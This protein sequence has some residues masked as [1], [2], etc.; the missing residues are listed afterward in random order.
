MSSFVSC[1][2][3]H[4]AKGVG[5]KGNLE[6]NWSQ[7]LEE[8]FVQLYFQLVRNDCDTIEECLD[9][10]I[11]GCCKP[12]HIYPDQISNKSLFIKLFKLIGHTRDIIS[13]KGEYQLTYRQILV[14]YKRFPELAK[15]ATACLVCNS[16]LDGK[17]MHPYGSFK[18][19]KY[20]SK[21]VLKETGDPDH[22]LI[23][24]CCSIF[25]SQVSFDINILNKSHEVGDI[26]LAGR[27]VPGEKSAFA[28]MYEK[29][30][31]YL[32]PDIIAS[33]INKNRDDQGPPMTDK[34]KKDRMNRAR[35]CTKQILRNCKTRLNKHLKTTQIY[36]T[37]NRFSDIDY[38]NVTSITMKNNKLAFQN[39]K[40]DGSQRST[41]EDR[42][43]AATKFSN[44]INETKSKGG[45]INGKR[46]FLYEIARDAW[47]L[48]DCYSGNVPDNDVNRD[49]INLQ[50]KDTFSQ[51]PGFNSKSGDNMWVPMVDL[52]G[53]MLCYDDGLPLYN[54]VALGIRISEM[55]S[56]HFKDRILS[57]SQTPSWINLENKDFCD[58]IKTMRAQSRNAGLNTNIYAAF[59][60]ILT[61]ILKYNIPPEEVK[62]MVIA[63][64]SDMQIDEASGDLKDLTLYEAIVKKYHDAGIKSTFNKPFEVPHILFWNL[65]KTDGFPVIS[66]QKNVT[67]LSGYNSTLLEV[68]S[69]KGMNG[70]AECSG[71]SMIDN[72]LSNPRY[73]L[74]AS[75][76]Q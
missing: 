73:N 53:S 54:A 18:D 4:T 55:N 56:N 20:L 48:G 31:Q 14:W 22:P 58:K 16:D 2:D 13:G 28:F 35:K 29:I 66:N 27:W 34:E 8:R 64:F 15:Y 32:N 30:A 3:Q 39:K 25:A 43:R 38:K 9:Q 65:R 46:C 74:L 57:F 51:T 11:T 45:V 62:R 21:Y 19:L 72:L 40:K 12:H 1:M 71:K 59:D 33:A 69:E 10:L 44:Y 61:V 63:I 37:S 42:I 5:E 67:T 7:D 75:K 6:Y 24:L 60:L 76:I 68:F 17:N 70:L 47:N 23:D 49:V 52:S 41:S 50:W 26:S 36:M